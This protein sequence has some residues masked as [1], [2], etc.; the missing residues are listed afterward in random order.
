MKKLIFA[1]MVLLVATSASAASIEVQE[2]VPANTVWSFSVTLPNGTDFDDAKVLL[3]GSRIISFETVGSN[4]TIEPFDEDSSRLFSST[5]PVGNTVYFLVSPLDDG[6]H[7]IV[8]KVDDST[9]DEESV[10]FFAIYDAGERADLQSQVNS[11]RGSVNSLV[12]QVNSV[13]EKLGNALTDED[14]QA[15][16]ASIDELKEAMLEMKTGLE[17]Q[18]ANSL[19]KINALNGYLQKLEER[20]SELENP[21]A[22]GIGL[23]S[24]AGI[25]PGAQAGILFVIVAIVAAVLV[26]KFKDR[27]P[28]KSLYG[29]PKKEAPVF[30]QRDEDIAAQVM[31]ESQDESKKGRWAVEGARP[32]EKPERKPFNIGDLLRKD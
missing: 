19:V 27:I 28:K 2:S 26:I 15:L 25:G 22:T 31:N 29:S 11:M 16:Q 23:V 32:V 8:L 10:D 4:Q 21:Q 17:G 13:E 3:D 14:R 1:L 7:D 9:V 18:D 30:S 5:E 12:S 20:T 6:A 24:L